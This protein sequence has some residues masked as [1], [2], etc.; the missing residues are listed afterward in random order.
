MRRNKPSDAGKVQPEQ[1]RDG[2]IWGS[3]RVI[4]QE[5]CVNIAAFPALE[6]RHPMADGFDIHLNE[7]Q[8]RRLKAAAEASGVDP[9][10]YVHRALAADG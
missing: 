6:H 3:I 1:I 7:G 8:A 5:H 10:T 9:A 4:Q 2:P